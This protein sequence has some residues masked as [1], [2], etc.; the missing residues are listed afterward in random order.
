MEVDLGD[1]ALHGAAWKGQV[2]AARLLI[3]AGARQD[4]KNKEQKLARDLAREPTVAT[5]FV[6]KKDPADE[7]DYLDD[8]EEEDD[9]EG[10]VDE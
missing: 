3:S 1:T 8:D 10:V 2:T 9:D 7:D 6:K 5:L 4:V